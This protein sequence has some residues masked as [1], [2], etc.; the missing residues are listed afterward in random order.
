MKIRPEVYDQDISEIASGEAY[1]SHTG[2]KGKILYDEAF[3]GDWLARMSNNMESSCGFLNTQR[4][5]VPFEV[6]W[7]KTN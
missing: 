6:I 1:R 3:G 5:I 2:L 4:R 7:C